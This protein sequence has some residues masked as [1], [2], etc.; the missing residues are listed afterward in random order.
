MKNTKEEQI[1]D[2]KEKCEVIILKY[3][4]PNYTGIEKY[5]I[6]T[7]LTEEELQSNYPDVID[8]YK[9]YVLLEKKAASVIQEY[10][11]NDDKFRKRHV[12]NGVSYTPDDETFF[13]T[14][15]EQADRSLES[16][17]MLKIDA[18]LIEQALDKLTL[19][20]KERIYKYFYLEMSIGEIAAQEGVNKNAVEK[21]IQGALKKLRLIL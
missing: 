13:I 21:S 5:A 12:N 16:D 17:I 6:L 15:P 4:Y 10:R 7:D 3:E 18:E 9:P 20:Q 14:H 2:F 19:I 1:A 11:Q 8:I